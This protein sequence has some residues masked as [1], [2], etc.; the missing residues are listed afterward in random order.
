M[1]VGSN[2]SIN[3]SSCSLLKHFAF[4]S[5][6]FWCF[7]LSW[8]LFARLLST[9]GFF[10][11]LFDKYFSGRLKLL[12][13]HCFELK[14]PYSWDGCDAVL[15]NSWE[16]KGHYGGVTVAVDSEDS[17]CSL[18]LLCFLYDQAL[19]GSF[20]KRFWYFTGHSY[21]SY[22]LASL[23]LCLLLV[24]NIS[25]FFSRNLFQ[26]SLFES[27]LL[28]LIRGLPILKKDLD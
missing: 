13:N 5:L 8:Y 15:L 14:A 2:R 11:G 1:S 4:R 7:M 22:F 6:F 26:Y 20:S 18:A 16:D 21:F 28:E 24:F 25:S 3:H 19:M 9:S 17:L 23:F 27:L 12:R 10:L